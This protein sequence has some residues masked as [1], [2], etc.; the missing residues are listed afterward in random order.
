MDTTKYLQHYVGFANERP[1]TNQV[2]VSMVTNQPHGGAEPDQRVAVA[3]YAF[4]HLSSDYQGGV[5]GRL[6][7]YFSDRRY[8]DLPR[9]PFDSNRTD[10]LGVEIALDGDTGRITLVGHSWGG[11]RHT[12]TDVQL[13]DGVLVASGPS[14][15]NQTTSALY[16]ISLGTAVAP[17]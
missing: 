16:V 5:N 9:P 1:G 7:Q 2:M 17:G 15:G 11:G 12:L 8:P 4:G 3:S 6:R 10:D 13:L 14:V